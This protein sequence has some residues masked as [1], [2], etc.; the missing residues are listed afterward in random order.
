MTETDRIIINQLARLCN[1]LDVPLDKEFE[2]LV[3]SANDIG[4]TQG[5]IESL[6]LNWKIVKIKSDRVCVSCKRI[7][8]AGTKCIT[9]AGFRKGSKM[10]GYRAWKCPECDSLDYGE[11][12]D[13]E[14]EET[15]YPE[16][17]DDF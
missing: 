13:A 15:R 4:F 8:P 14:Y 17:E 5:Q 16:I 10:Q 6:G 7:I 1:L 3:K 11:A 2:T 12:L 9:F